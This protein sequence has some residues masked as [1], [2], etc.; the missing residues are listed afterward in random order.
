MKT[1]VCVVVLFFPKTLASQ[2][3]S[4]TNDTT[5]T[6]TYIH[7]QVTRWSTGEPVYSY[8]YNTNSDSMEFT[9]SRYEGKSV[10]SKI[11]IDTNLSSITN[12]LIKCID[13]ITI[14]PKHKPVKQE[15]SVL[16]LISNI[17][18]ERV[19]YISDHH[20]LSQILMT[21][22]KFN[23]SLP[24]KYRFPSD[25]SRNKIN[26]PLEKRI[27]DIYLDYCRGCENPKDKHLQTSKVV[28]NSF[29]ID[30]Y[31]S[32]EKKIKFRQLV[33]FDRTKT[34]VF[35][36]MALDYV[37]RFTISKQR[38]PKPINPLEAFHVSYILP[39]IIVSTK[40]FSME[41]AFQ[42]KMSSKLLKYINVNV[43]PK[44]SF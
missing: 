18:Y 3:L 31:D 9:L 21:L 17:H 7:L 44:Y 41:R 22:N 20:Y 43:R 13:K 1:L 16:C 14:D 5:D 23:V 42:D 28:E 40:I 8:D 4:E 33:K 30:A 24:V 11:Y 26:P 10:Y 32:V 19:I 25:F 38:F 35:N 39:G 12:E 34:E 15:F 27:V 36:S 29:E 6:S 37:N 2:R